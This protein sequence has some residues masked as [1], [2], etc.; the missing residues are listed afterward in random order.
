MSET[1]TIRNLSYHFISAYYFSQG[2]GKSF[3]IFFCFDRRYCLTLEDVYFF[4]EKDGS[5]ILNSE[6]AS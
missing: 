3:L 2:L 6:E 5:F 1:E 4:K